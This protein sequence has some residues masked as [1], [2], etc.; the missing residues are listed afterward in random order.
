MLSHDVI[1][2]PKNCPIKINW[3]RNARQILTESSK[4]CRQK[5][6]ESIRNGSHG[7][8]EL[9]QLCR[10][11]SL[12]IDRYYVHFTK[13]P[14]ERIEYELALMNLK[15]C[16]KYHAMIP[17]GPQYIRT[18]EKSVYIG[19][20]TLELRELCEIKNGIKIHTDFPVLPPHVYEDQSPCLGD[21]SKAY[22]KLRRLG[23]L[24][25]I[26]ALMSLFLSSYN[27]NSATR[28]IVD[29]VIL[30]NQLEKKRNEKRIQDQSLCLAEGSLVSQEG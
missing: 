28:S 25:D 8:L 18:G 5:N 15:D 22:F 1:R 19:N 13:T 6:H 9:A 17:I 23:Y 26:P 7:F 4:L 2:R 20:I 21:F 11:A 29:Y 12:S 27:P 24:S 10:N 14:L 3:L 16:S 30:N